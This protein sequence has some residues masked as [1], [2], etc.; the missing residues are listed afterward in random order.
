MG[1]L[2]TV[3]VVFGASVRQCGKRA[4]FAFV[5]I[6]DSHCFEGWGADD[7]FEACGTPG[8]PENAGLACHVSSGAATQRRECRPPI[9]RQI[10]VG[11]LGSA[12]GG[13]EGLGC[14]FRR[15]R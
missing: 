12:R 3:L 2:T 4:E 15:R 5:K 14:S 1:R 11:Q 9:C 7:T 8:R 6:F 13:I 10:E